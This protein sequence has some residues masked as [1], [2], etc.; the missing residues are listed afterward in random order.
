MH[1]VDPQQV[2]ANSQWLTQAE[3]FDEFCK[4]KKEHTTNWVTYSGGNPCI[5]DLT[6]LTNLLQEQQIQIAVETQGTFKPEW[7][8]DVE[9]ITVSPKGPGM[10][11]KYEQD[12]LDAFISEFQDHEGLNMK[13]VVFDQRDL[14]FAAMLYERYVVEGFLDR[15]QFYLS[16]GNPF[17]PG[18]EMVSPFLQEVGL[19]QVLIDRY[20]Q[21]LEDVLHD[22]YL[23]EVKFLPQLHVLLWHNKQGV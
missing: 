14:E 1:A 11:E 16:L 6:D 8:W 5:H 17:P 7:L 9:I 21:L 23:C 3:I 4:F 18:H 20:R 10:G 22:K 12:K 2:K 13:I 19:T 15:S